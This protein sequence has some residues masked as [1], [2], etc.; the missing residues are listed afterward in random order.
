MKR[1]IIPMIV[2]LLGIS[3]IFSNAS[4]GSDALKCDT[5]GVRI[6][7]I[8]GSG[9]ES[10]LVGAHVSEVPGVVTATNSKGFFM[11]DNDTDC[12]NATSE[13]IYVYA[14]NKTDVNVS[15]YLQ[16]SGTVSEYFGENSLSLTEITNPT[17]SNRSASSLPDPT[18]IG[19]NGRVPP[20]TVI[21]D[22]GFA[23]TN[24]NV[25]GTDFYE[26][27]EGMLVTIKDAVV[28][29]PSG[30]DKPIF[31]LVDN[32]TGASLRSERGGI[33]LRPFDAN[34]ERIAVSYKKQ[35]NQNI[36]VSDKINGPITGV[37]TYDTYSNNYQ[38]LVNGTLGVT[39][40]NIHPETTQN[41]TSGE[42]TIATY[43]VDNLVP[44]PKGELDRLNKVGKQIATNLKSPDIIVL[45]EI[46]DNS[47]K[48]DN[49]VVDADQTYKRLIEAIQRS[50]GP[51]YNYINI[52]PLNNKDGGGTGYNIRVGIL[53]RMDRGLEFV[54]R[55]GGDAVTST[56]VINDGSGPHLSYSPGRIDPTN[57]A[58]EDNRKPLAAEFR[59][60]NSTLFV[61]G[62]H[63]KSK[64][65]DQPLY[66]RYQPLRRSTENQRHKQS[67]VV[68]NFVKE[69]LRADPNANIVALGDLND[70]QF[71]ETL[72]I[73]KGA[74]LTDV[75]ETL[76][77]NE[78]YT[79][80]FDGNSQDLDHI[81]VSE[82]INKSGFETDVIHINSEFGNQVSDHDPVIVRIKPVQEGEMPSSPIFK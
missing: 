35:S 54:N 71:S 41:A 5:V 36:N 43:N 9:H 38:L 2:T 34:P 47:G 63:F 59:Y 55:T 76:P 81:L 14:A 49:S 70:F 57:E 37:L 74:D 58:F 4:I 80:V 13:G 52:N 48:T 42:L 68:N 10:P 21:D 79:Y 16:V 82:N 15:E 17:I 11:Q 53:Y 25:D 12:R 40:G 69:I 8:Q 50:N 1:R 62:N 33:L 78:Q 64:G 51:T 73:L 32:G 30:K 75:I 61:I 46:G 60:N 65:E 26:S 19:I 72:N 23:D 44:S 24:I 31:V 39:P 7:D 45:E 66:G 6:H 67:Y 3:I 28:I 22:D 77:P 27:L 56:T 18:L 29:G 20:S